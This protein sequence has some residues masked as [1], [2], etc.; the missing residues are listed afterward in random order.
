MQDGDVD[1]DV[2]PPA[3]WRVGDHC[4]V[5]EGRLQRF[6]LDLQVQHVCKGL[7]RI[8]SVGE[9]S[10]CGLPVPGTGAGE[11][12][13]AGAGAESGAGAGHTSS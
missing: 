9:Q 7:Q 1:V 5:M 2:Q 3:L 12:A 4:S 11:E 10:Q 6:I 13:K 8:V